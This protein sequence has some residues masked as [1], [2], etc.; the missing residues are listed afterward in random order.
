MRQEIS[1]PK[2][3]DRDSFDSLVRKLLPCVY[4]RPLRRRLW[5][6]TVVM[7]TYP[8]CRHIIQAVDT[9]HTFEE[10]RT[11]LYARTLQPLVR[12]L[13]DNVQHPAI[14]SALL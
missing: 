4:Y 7:L 11:T 1:T 12:H 8:H 6:Q 2:I 14:V 5:L 13:V 10:L 9:Q 3:Q